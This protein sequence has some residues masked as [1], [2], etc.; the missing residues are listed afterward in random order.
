MAT[1]V[2]LVCVNEATKVSRYLMEG[3]K[4]YLARLKLGLETDTQDVTGRVLREADWTG[5]TRAQIEEAVAAFV[6]ELQQV[7]PMYSALKQKGVRLHTL[8]RRGEEVERLPRKVQVYRM[9]LEDV[10]LPEATLRINCSR[11]TYVRTIVADLGKCLG[12]GATLA[13]LRRTRSGGFGI[14][15]AVP[16]A[17]L[18]GGGAAVLARRLI[19][20]PAALPDWTELCL[21]AEAAAKAEQGHPPPAPA[22]SR[23]GERIKLIGPGGG[24]VALTE[25]AI[26]P[27]GQLRLK[28]LRVFHCNTATQGLA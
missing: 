28:T 26:Q 22:E 18:S 11:G 12:S 13:S 2:L 9:E 17:E 25:A 1:G 5:I 16:L 4:E 8:A 15:Q 3:D 10:S 6:G 24:L 20:L 7:P 21:D 14:A 27:S 19:P 23:S